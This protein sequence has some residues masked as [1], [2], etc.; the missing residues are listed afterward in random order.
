[1]SQ[2]M[3]QTVPQ[4]SLSFFSL[5]KSIPPSSP[6]SAT[7]CLFL[8]SRSI[9][10]FMWH[11]CVLT[12]LACSRLVGWQRSSCYSVIVGGKSKKTDFSY[13]YLPL[14]YGWASANDNV[15]N[16]T[17][18]NHPTR[19]CFELINAKQ[20]LLENLYAVINRAAAANTQPHSRTLLPHTH[21]HTH[22][23]ST[24]C[25]TMTDRYRLSEQLWSSKTYPAIIQRTHPRKL[26]FKQTSAV[27]DGA[28]VVGG[29]SVKNG[30]H[31][32]KGR[33]GWRAT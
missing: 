8:T 29:R 1:M 32:I 22:F 4:I 26:A 10:L 28:L 13:L 21:T 24:Q 6:P 9:S 30:C 16:D 33:M 19:D 12:E 23:M 7:V 11:F 14:Y 25:H 18:V 31:R 20:R 27:S 17:R 15:G 5:E 3:T 2:L